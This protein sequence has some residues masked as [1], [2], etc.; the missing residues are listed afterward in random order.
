[1]ELFTFEGAKSF[2]HVKAFKF[3]VK[4]IFLGGLVMVRELHNVLFF[5]KKK[6]RKNFCQDVLL[7]RFGE[8]YILFFALHGQFSPA[9][10]GIGRQIGMSVNSI[11]GIGRQTGIS[12]CRCSHR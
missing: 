5:F 3:G 11:Q 12:V 4:I 2:S 9:L 1:M 10:H 8:C 7:G 6:K